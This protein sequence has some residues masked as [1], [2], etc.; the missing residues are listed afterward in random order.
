MQISIAAT[1]VTLNEVIGLFND[2]F[3]NASCTTDGSP[4]VAKICF[5]APDDD[6]P[7]LCV[8]LRIWDPETGQGEVESGGR[9]VQLTSCIE[10]KGGRVMRD[11]VNDVELCGDT[12][13]LT[14]LR[15]IAALDMTICVFNTSCYDRE[16]FYERL[17]EVRAAYNIFALR[18]SK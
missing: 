2:F 16:A 14:T 4:T 6:M 5:P 15:Q 9:A 1:P 10:G 8:S 13:Y 12:K 3:P 18:W 11:P 7:R 17:R